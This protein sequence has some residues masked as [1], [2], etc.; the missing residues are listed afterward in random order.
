MKLA[1]D[2]SRFPNLQ[3]Q[4]RFTFRL[5]VSQ[6]F[7]HVKAYVTEEGFNLTAILALITVL[8]TAFGNLDR[9]AITERKLED[10]K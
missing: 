6:T 8:E 7:T 9:V 4:L 2:T 10:L 3:H 1:G 5:L